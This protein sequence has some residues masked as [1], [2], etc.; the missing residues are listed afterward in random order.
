MASKYDFDDKNP[1]K[2][3]VQGQ[4]GFGPKPL[5]APG[6]GPLQQK[7]TNFALNT[8]A[9]A[10]MGFLDK[11]ALPGV[12]QGLTGFSKV[13][14]GPMASIAPTLGTAVTTMVPWLGLGYGLG[15]VFNWWNA[16][17]TNVQD[18][19]KMMKDIRMRGPL[20]YGHGTHSVPKKN[21]Q[22]YATGEI[23]VKA[24]LN[25]DN[26]GGLST[27][28]A[29]VQNSGFIPWTDR[30]M[31]EKDGFDKRL[32]IEVNDRQLINDAIITMSEQADALGD[33]GDINRSDRGTDVVNRG[34]SRI[35]AYRNQLEDVRS[36]IS[37]GKGKLSPGLRA[38]LNRITGRLP[39]GGMQPAPGPWTD[40]SR[41]DQ[42][43]PE[44]TPPP[45]IPDHLMPYNDQP[46]PITQAPYNP[47]S[48]FPS[49]TIP[50]DPRES[51]EPGAKNWPETYY[52][53]WEAEFPPAN[54]EAD[55]LLEQYNYNIDHHQPNYGSNK[56][57]SMINSGEIPAKPPMR[58]FSNSLQSQR[59][60]AEWNDRY[61]PGGSYH[62]NKAN[63]AQF[64]RG[65]D[66]NMQPRDINYYNK[67]EGGP[68]TSLTQFKKGGDVNMQPN[69]TKKNKE[70][71]SWD[72][73]M[74]TKNEKLKQAQIA[75]AA[76]TK[77][78]HSS[79]T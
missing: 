7:A 43:P 41:G 24:P 18:R 72:L 5:S 59:D 58:F 1:D 69:L 60:R 35:E 56:I 37:D 27:D 32:R 71:L 33:S 70:D 64:K 65:G 8:G 74:Q 4:A 40:P 52:R 25:P 29:V 13:A 36:R 76:A 53:L 44:F 50:G 48:L 57:S 49:Q 12:G 20:A 11:I 3:R 75:T 2:N 47:R 66:V 78:L 55:A 16:G 61:G 23:D 51:M 30:E 10:G 77:A 38:E 68:L 67:F 9:K 54:K 73:D 34:K 45:S 21:V 26:I 19:S 42:H 63:Y 14:A 22:Y 39:E 6:P 62:V 15:K 17:T 79:D 46:D 28:P 31:L